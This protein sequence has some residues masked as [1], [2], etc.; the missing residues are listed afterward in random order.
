[1]V[2]NF[3]YK[4]QFVHQKYRYGEVSLWDMMVIERYHCSILRTV[5]AGSGPA[6]LVNQLAEIQPIASMA[7]LL[8]TLLVESKLFS[9]TSIPAWRKPSVP[10]K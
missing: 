8:S 3:P 4:H 10:K 5:V 9:L 1:M 6:N 2:P 7:Y